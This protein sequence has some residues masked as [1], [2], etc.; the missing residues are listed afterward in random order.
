M[1]IIPK[2][3]LTTLLLL[4]LVYQG[5]AQQA[6]Q[7]IDSL[8]NDQYNLHEMQ[9][10]VLVASKGKVVYKHSFGYAD[11]AGK[12]LM[13]EQAT[14][15]LA[16]VSKIFTAVAILQLKE[17]GKLKL[18]DAVSKYLSDFPY[19]HI[20]I[21]G[22]LSHTSGLT[23]GFQVFEKPHSADTGKIFSNADVIPA[24]RQ[25]PKE[26]M[27]PSGERFE[28]SNTGYCVLALI[29]EKVSGLSYQD[30]MT[31]YIFE[32]ARMQQ[33]YVSTKLIKK[34]GKDEVK[35]YDFISYAPGRFKNVD[36]VK[37]NYIGLTIL[38]GVLGPSNIY[39][40]TGDM[41]LFDRALYRSKL[42]QPATLQEA[43]T[44]TKLNNGEYATTGWKNTKAYYGLGLMILCD[45]TH[46]RI[47]FHSGG[48]SG[49]VTIFLRN[50]THNQTVIMLDN[51]THRGLHTIGINLMSLLNNGPVF[52]PKRSLAKA[53]TTALFEK[54]P[55]YA[56]SRFNTLKEDTVHYAMNE[57]ELNGLGLDLLYD[58]YQDLAVE[59]LKLNTILYP[60]SWNVYD[61]YAEALLKVD[62]KEEAIAMYEQSIRINPQNEPGK[63]ALA[64]I[65]GK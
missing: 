58:G 10:N 48:I 25:V 22:L 14:F 27:R 36:S 39:S 37:R 5:Y 42:L 26:M 34:T 12:V 20:S 35:G 33:T 65:K 1:K 51:V 24:I 3:R 46:G 56:N 38:G 6:L 8:V 23:G 52:T 61:S 55:D 64:R 32:P 7:Q 54:G 16:S 63:K 60:A 59:A 18:D 4:S 2:T 47:V 44:P 45:S 43:L 62:K 19:D 49:S 21:R 41:L 40:T 50:I 9:G 11:V 13:N 28:Y 53:Y 29:I 15:H 57:M 30:Y 17:K 31:K